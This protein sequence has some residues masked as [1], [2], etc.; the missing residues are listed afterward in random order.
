MDTNTTNAF[1]NVDGLD[2]PGAIAIAR[3][4]GLRRDWARVRLLEIAKMLSSFPADRLIAAARATPDVFTDEDIELLTDPDTEF[5]EDDAGDDALAETAEQSDGDS[6]K[7]ATAA[8]LETKATAQQHAAPDVNQVASLLAQLMATAKA[9][10]DADDVRKIVAPMLTDAA[11]AMAETSARII[12]EALDGMPPRSLEVKTERSTVKLE[13]FQHKE[14]EALLGFCAAV[15]YKGDRLNVWLYGPP[16]TG[17]T[18]AAMNAAKALD[19]PFLCNG[20]LASKYELIGFVDANGKYQTTPFRE[21]WEKG[22]V[23]C[24]DEIDGS[25]QKTLIAFNSALAN[26]IMAFPD[27]MVKRHPDCVIIA[28]SNTVYGATAEFTARVKQDGASIDRFV[29]LEW[30]VD[31]Q[32]ELALCSNKE[33]AKEVQAHRRKVAEKGVKVL[34]TPRATFFGEALLRQGVAIEKVRQAVLR[35]A[36]TTEQWNLVVNG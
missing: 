21:A 30:L 3:A 19:M 9:G 7:A 25:D 28:S 29:F 36:M 20:A 13:G 35:K 22:G 4:L 16:G 33:W 6:A 26:G 14:F 24:F 2:K 8:I 10:V 27:G 12:R 34:I 11:A 1:F 32:L 31:E 15:D 5:N 18:T 23:Y 17:K